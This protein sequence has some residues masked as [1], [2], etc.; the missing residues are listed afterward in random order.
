MNKLS[1]KELREAAWATMAAKRKPRR[2]KVKPEPPPAPSWADDCERRC[3]AQDEGCE[4]SNS[5][6]YVFWGTPPMKMCAS[7]YR[8]L[9]TPIKVAPAKVLKPR[10]V[11]VDA[12]RE[13]RV[14]SW[15]RGRR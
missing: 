5:R 2:E 8:L 11:T 1:E 6:A 3:E 13:K 4:G 15:Q 10:S 7:C 9:I 12:T 14:E